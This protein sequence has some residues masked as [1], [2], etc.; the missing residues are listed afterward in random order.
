[1]KMKFNLSSQ[2]YFLFVIFLIAFFIRL[3]CIDF[4]SLWLDEIY[5]M[6]M[7]DPKNSISDIY[8]LSKV[9]D[10]LSVLYFVLLNWCFKIFAYTSFVA[11]FF[12]L[13][14]GL[15]GIWFTY[16]LGKEL[17]NR[18]TGLIAAVLLSVNFFHIYYSQEARVY[19][20]YMAFSSLS[21][22]YLV[23]FIKEPNI[24]SSLYYGLSTLLMILSHFYGLFALLA[25][26]I[27]LFYA[28]FHLK[29]I[30]QKKFLIHSSVSGLIVILGFL[31]VIPILLMF[32]KATSTWMP[33][34]NTNTFSTV[35]SDFFGNSNLLFSFAVLMIMFYLFNLFSEKEYLAGKEDKDLFSKHVPVFGVL[36]LWII[37]TFFVPY[38][39]SFLKIP[40]I[41]SRYMSTFLP[42]VLI[43][44]AI[45][46]EIIGNKKL[47]AAL[48]AL[49]V[50]ISFVEIVLE[51]SYYSKP[52]KSNFRDAARFLVDNNSPKAK[53]YT[54]LPYHF[55]YYFRTFNNTAVV[56][57]T[58][59][60]TVFSK[61]RARKISPEAFW[62]IDAHGRTLNLLD[63]NKK[64][65]ALN[66]EEVM[67]F[68]GLDSWAKFYIPRSS[69]DSPGHV[70]T[71]NSISYFEKPPYDGDTNLYLYSN[72][73]LISK[74]LQLDSGNY[75]LVL[76]ARSTPTEPINNTNAHIKVFIDDRQLRAYY[77]EAR[78]NIYG[79]TLPFQ[80]ENKKALLLKIEF[81]N[82]TSSGKLD[83]NVVIREI[84]IIKAH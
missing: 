81:D 1:M 78:T 29:T 76:K 60:D 9:Q 82:D 39:R 25:Q 44:A 61:L 15:L 19:T 41:Q 27:A 42:A 71:L 67:K 38:T 75:K 21:F 56:D 23:R 65:L 7:A 63:S 43:M 68:D 45:G 48:V 53:I 83:R 22:Y 16:L 40:M 31:P 54:S 62:A 49:F 18:N 77:L 32:N 55:D 35:F 79:D 34:P 47:K 12:S 58:P 66:F 5:T 57:A 4:Q 46:F 13:F 17:R 6:N 24:R 28:S 84:Q 11:R 59:L 26:L 72:G 36:G 10:G 74:P 70:F 80:V 51:R 20:M 30:S 14:F 33:M 37:I 50:L 3:F 69:K 52:L 73:T 8:E 2:N 64:Y